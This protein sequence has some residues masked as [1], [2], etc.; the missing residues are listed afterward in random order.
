MRRSAKNVGLSK[1]NQTTN[2]LVGYSSEKFTEELVKVDWP[3]MSN[4]SVN[5]KAKFLSDN[6]ARCINVF[7]KKVPMRD[8]HNMWYTNELRLL[9]M[10]KNDQYKLAVLTDDEVEWINF[11]NVSTLYS[12]G[13][14]NAKNLYYHTKLFD[15]KND[16]MRTWRVLKEIVNGTPSENPAE[17]DFC[18]E[19]ITDE[20]LIPDKFNA[21]FVNSIREIRES[22]PD[23]HDDFSFDVDDS[24]RLE[25]DF[26]TISLN[27]VKSSLHRIKSNGD[28]QFLNKRVMLD[29][30]NVIGSQLVDLINSSLAE[31]FPE[32]WKNSTIVPTQKK[33]G[34]VKCEEFRPINMLPTYE[35]ILEDIVKQQ[36]EKYVDARKIIVEKQSGFRPD[37][38]CESALNLVLMEW[39]AEMEKG[40]IILAIFLDLKRAFETIDRQRLILKLKKYGIVGK[41]LDW[42]ISYLANR[43]QCTTYSGTTSRR[44]EIEYGVPQ[45]AKLSSLL[46]LLYI[47]D[48]GNSI[49]KCKIVLFADDTLIYVCSPSIDVAAQ[50]MNEDLE[51]VDRWLSVNRLK[52]NIQKTKYMIL[53]YKRIDESLVNIRIGLNE[54]ERVKLMKYLGVLIDDQL[55]MS[56]HVEYT[57]KKVAKKIGFFRRISAKLNFQNRLTLYKSIISPHFDYCATILFLGKE[58]DLDKLQIQQNRAMRIILRGNSIKDMLKALNFLDVRQRINYLTMA[59]KFKIKNGQLPQYLTREINYVGDAQHYNLRNND[60]FRLPKVSRTSSKNCLYYK[61]LMEFNHLPTDVKDQSDIKMFKRRLIDFLRKV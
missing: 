34:T 24:D 7:V 60:D 49:K 4:M 39:K 10:K 32:I 46:F 11:K 21:F 59:F 20:E 28:V 47:N 2:R 3:I 43:T 27:D 50:Q 26:K 14:Q 40:N 15:A 55:S 16:Q 57:C 6:L 30:M 54:I 22:I 51:N 12:N 17:I 8:F 37:H 58:A 45:G 5:D 1:S 44:L 48:I 56:Q 52:I 23:G 38:S 35:K 53:S 61:G 13:V 25:F 42:F 41:E 36:V 31:G 29:A 19:L 18:G 9:R 33:S